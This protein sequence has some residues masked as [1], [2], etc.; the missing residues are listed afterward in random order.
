MNTN[1]NIVTTVQRVFAANVPAA[2]AANASVVLF[3]THP[4]ALGTG[5]AAYVTQFADSGG[6]VVAVDADAIEAVHLIYALHDHASAANGLRAYQTLDGGATWI[7]TDMK[8]PDN[9]GTIGATVPIQVPTLTAG[10]EWS[11]TFHI[12]AYRGFALVHTAGATG[13]T[14]NTGWALAISAQYSP[15]GN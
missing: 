14:A 9:V 10:H 7:E 6:G 12:G 5:G 11:E 2:P 13:P 8:G 4:C 1:P 3:A 15:Q